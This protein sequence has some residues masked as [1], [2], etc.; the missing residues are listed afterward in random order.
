MPPVVAAAGEIW[1][2]VLR[3]KLEE[4]DCLNVLHFQTPLG[5]SDVVEHLIRAIIQCVTQRLVNGQV[6]TF[7]FD[8]VLA[9]RV[10]PTLGPDVELT[11]EGGIFPNEGQLAEDGLPSYCSCVVS[12]KTT[13]G[14]RSG[15]GR[16]FIGGVPETS[17][18]G[19]RITIPSAFWT[20]LLAFIACVVE[21]F[22]LGDPPVANT[23]QLGV[24]SRKLGGAKPPFA[25]AG[26][27]PATSLTP[28]P[29]LATTRSRK[30]GHGS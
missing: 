28:K 11:A 18:V 22:F 6:N 24:M 21:K 15:K 26:F 20:A 7:V 13:R 29:L 12:I 27:A 19:S 30:I 17:T 2:V 3:S 14:G 25:A 16:M 8:S 23:W 10:S 5:D 9:R 1:Q 4:Q